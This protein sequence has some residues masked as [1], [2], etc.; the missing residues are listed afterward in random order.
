MDYIQKLYKLKKDALNNIMDREKSGFYLINGYNFKFDD[1]SR[2][3]KITNMIDKWNNSK[4]MIWNDITQSM[5][6]SNIVEKRMSFNIFV[7]NLKIEDSLLS[8][9]KTKNKI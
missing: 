1:I 2:L 4:K 3:E 9:G 7:R 5:D 8:F 6:N